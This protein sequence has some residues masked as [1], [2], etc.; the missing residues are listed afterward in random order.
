[1][2]V[3][4]TAVIKRHGEDDAGYGEDKVVVQATAEFTDDTTV[5]E[6]MR[7][8]KA[9]AE[10]SNTLVRVVTRARFSGPTCFKNHHFTEHEEVLRCCTT[11]SLRMKELSGTRHDAQI[12]K[13]VGSVLNEAG[14]DT[15][16]G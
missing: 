15:S 3:R 13:L 9:A 11:L 2:S 12:M 14:Y 1:M 8:V 6:I 16:L 5:R 10:M 4:K 7:E